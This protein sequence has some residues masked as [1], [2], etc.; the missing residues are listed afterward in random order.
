MKKCIFS[1][2]FEKGIAHILF[3]ISASPGLNF[4]KSMKI[5]VQKMS[6]ISEKSVIRGWSSV[7]SSKKCT[8][9]IV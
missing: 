7:V 9:H 6:D 5:A 1:V 3:I 4:I 2:G 8:C